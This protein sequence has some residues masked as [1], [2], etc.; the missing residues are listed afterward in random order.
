MH[1]F[2]T[3]FLLA[4]MLAIPNLAAMD[5]P[6][7]TGGWP[8]F[9]GNPALTGIAEGSLEFPMTLLWTTK[10]EDAIKSSPIVAGGKLYIGSDDGGVY[11][12]DAGTGKTLWKFMTG[13]PVEAAPLLLDGTIYIG[14]SDFKFY[15]LDAETGKTRWEF[16]TVDKILGAANY[17]PAPDGNG[18]WILFGGYD[19]FLYCLNAGTGELVWKYGVESYINGTP[20]VTGET[21]AVG[22]CDANLHIVG[23]RDGKPKH[24]VP[25]EQYVAGS[26]AISHGD[27]YFGHY[28][29]EVVGIDLENGERLWRYKHKS[30]PY[31]SS[32]AVTDDLVVIGGRD[33]TIHCL[34]RKDGTAIWT[35]RTRGRIDSSPAIAGNTV[36][37]GSEDGRIYALN[38]EDGDKVWTYDLG[39][40]ITSSPAI[41]HGRI[42][43]GANDGGIYAFGPAPNSK[44]D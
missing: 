14:S 16:E 39:D 3:S 35:V 6:T 2:P 27:V 34:N 1:H 24:V 40:K 36:I 10:T 42:Y 38:L 9:R 23:L 13:G 25:I 41:V 28:G 8:Q 18:H 44:G 30:F 19:E 43:I 17:A 29:N 12:L 26:A 15:A 5:Q 31:F 11:A 37:A 4:A 7:A 20:A 21:V 33:K 32:P 22:G